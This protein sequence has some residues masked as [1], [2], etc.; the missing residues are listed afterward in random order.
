MLSEGK[1]ASSAAFAVGY[2][3]VS[4]FTQMGVVCS[5]G[6]R[7]A[8]MVASRRSVFTRSPGFLWNQ[9]R[10]HH[11]APMAQA[12]ELAINAITARAGLIAKRQRL[13]GPPETIALFAEWKKR[14]RQ[15][16]RTLAA[17]PPHPLSATAIE[18]RSL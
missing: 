13:A 2:E 8:S 7:R 16:R 9:R 18:I 10:R 1:T 17:E 4:Q 15:S 12:C 14:H 3:S 5:A 6:S 11:V